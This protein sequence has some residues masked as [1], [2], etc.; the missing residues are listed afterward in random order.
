MLFTNNS[1]IL[2]HPVESPE[3]EV[4]LYS[5]SNIFCNDFPPRA[6]ELLAVPIK[7]LAYKVDPLIYTDGLLY[8]VD[9]LVV[10]GDPI[11]YEFVEFWTDSWEVGAYIDIVLLP[12][13][14]PCDPLIDGV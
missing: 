12:S 13:T 9:I 5:R 4:P 11:R 3:F 7:L 2:N 8:T 10:L 6:E 14:V 1:P